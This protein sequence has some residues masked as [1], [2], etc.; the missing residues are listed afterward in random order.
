[1]KK[2]S[3][4]HMQFLVEEAINNLFKNNDNHG[5]TYDEYLDM[6][7]QLAV[8]ASMQQEINQKPVERYLN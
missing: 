6:T 7:T 1:M 3:Y 4:E 8:Y 2:I 5:W